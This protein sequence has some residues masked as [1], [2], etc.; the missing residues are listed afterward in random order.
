MLRG[1]L[2]CIGC[3]SSQGA[4]C[5]FV[6]QFIYPQVKLFIILLVQ[7]NT[8]RTR[9]T[10]VAPRTLRF[11]HDRL[12]FSRTTRT[13]L[14]DPSDPDIIKPFIPEGLA[15]AADPADSSSSKGGYRRL[16]AIYG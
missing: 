7:Y 1:L 3:P 11:T 9:C 4:L 2:V 14:R 13:Q 6:S 15:V 8:H 12:L 5:M 10:P 16:S